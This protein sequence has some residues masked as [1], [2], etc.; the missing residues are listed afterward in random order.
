MG[1]GLQ[2]LLSF[3]ALPRPPCELRSRFGLGWDDARLW[4]S[5]FPVLYSVFPTPRFLFPV[6]CSLNLDFQH[7]VEGDAGP[8]FDGLFHLDLVDDAAFDEVFEGPGEV[9]RADAI[10]G[11]AEAPGIIQ[12]DDLFALFCK[13]FGEAVHQR[14]LNYELTL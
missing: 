10:H 6:L 11:G 5:V 2:P 3:S 8:V 9:L 13:S 14:A 4:R 1:S 7:S 12:G